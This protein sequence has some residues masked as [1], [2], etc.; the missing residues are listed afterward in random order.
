MSKRAPVF[1]RPEGSLF[2]VHIGD[3]EEVEL[4]GRARFLAYPIGSSSGQIVSSREAAESCLREMMEE[5]S[6]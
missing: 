2:L 6:G 5:N 4:A 1:Y 3:I